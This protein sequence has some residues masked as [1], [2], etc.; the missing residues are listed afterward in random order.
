MRD[1]GGEIQV[2]YRSPEGAFFVAAMTYDAGW[3]AFVDGRPL[4]TY[5]TA[6]CQL[7]AALPAGEHRLVLRYGEPLVGAGAGI[8][9]LALAGGAGAL[10]GFGR[11]RR[12]A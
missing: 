5:P 4:P 8:S 3:R 9:L 10:L 2:G 7:G 12:V 11:R 1:L 6:A